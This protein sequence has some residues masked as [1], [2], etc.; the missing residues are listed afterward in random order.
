MW[1]WVGNHTKCKRLLQVISCFQFQRINTTTQL[2]DLWWTFTLNAAGYFRPSHILLFNACV[3]QTQ[4]HPFLI[5]SKRDV[6]I[7]STLEIIFPK[8]GRETRQQTDQRVRRPFQ[9]VTPIPSL[10][11]HSHE[12][13][14]FLH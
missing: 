8:L 14:Y 12:D 13:E 11:C 5:R 1:D 2:R 9:P 4:G 6:N 7:W 10:S 3:W